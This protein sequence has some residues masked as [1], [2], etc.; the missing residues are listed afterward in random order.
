MA[1]APFAAQQQRLNAAVVSRLADAIAEVNGVQFAVLFDMPYAAPF[2][3]QIDSA[4]PT[5]LGASADLAGLERGSAIAI[6]GKPYR[7]ERAEPDGTG[8]TRL[9]LAEA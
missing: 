9:F 6:G 5:C 7:V 1:I 8:M 4:A 2:D 3:G